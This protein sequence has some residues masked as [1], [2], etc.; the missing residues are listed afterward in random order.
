MRTTVWH[1]LDH[2]LVQSTLPLF[3]AMILTS[4]GTTSHYSWTFQDI[5]LFSESQLAHFD[6]RTEPSFPE[7]RQP[8]T[9][10]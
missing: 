5:L 3:H 1:E 2:R 4:N 6:L 8:E 7:N 9:L 10:N